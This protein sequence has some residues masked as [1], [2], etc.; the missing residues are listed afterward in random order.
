MK[1]WNIYLA[2]YERGAAMQFVGSVRARSEPKARLRS[3]EKQY[4][5]LY[6]GRWSLVARLA[7][8]DDWQRPLPANLQQLRA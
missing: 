3:M 4:S 6:Q 1:L 5:G 8:V 2:T 7:E